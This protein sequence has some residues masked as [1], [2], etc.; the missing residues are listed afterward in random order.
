M[1]AFGQFNPPP[2]AVPQLTGVF[3]G[4]VFGFYAEAI[5]DPDNL[6]NE[7]DESESDNTAPDRNIYTV[8]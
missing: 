7:S 2:I 6:I 4:T 1:S 5:V 3:P 8:P